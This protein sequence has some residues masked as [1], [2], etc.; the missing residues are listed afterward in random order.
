MEQELKLHE[1]E[2]RFACI[3]WEHEPLSSGELA[4]LC[5]QQLNWQ[6]TTTYTVLKK[7]CTKGFFKNENA[8]VTALIKKEQVQQYE[9]RKVLENLF[10]NSLPAFLTAFMAGKKISEDEA[11]AL[12]ALID[13]CHENDDERGA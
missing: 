10:D 6:R 4:Q 9:S 11:E 3:I 5:R 7:L 1:A 13:R 8:V 12:K 2:Y